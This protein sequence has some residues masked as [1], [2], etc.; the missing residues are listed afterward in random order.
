MNREQ[1]R[2]QADQAIAHR[3][4]RRGPRDDYLGVVPGWCATE[5]DLEELRRQTHDLLIKLLG[6]SRTSGVTWRQYSGAA[7]LSAVTMLRLDA[8]THQLEWVAMCDEL[9][10]KLRDEGGYLV[11]ATAE[12]DPP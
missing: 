3:L 11:I 10:R 5:A 2:A 7:A 6:E 1:R 9:E 12:G 4:R 8:V